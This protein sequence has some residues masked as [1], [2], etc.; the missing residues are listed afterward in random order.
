MTR[1]EG[2]NQSPDAKNFENKKCFQG[3]KQD[4]NEL[5]RCRDHVR[6]SKTAPKSISKKREKLFKFT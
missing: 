4:E 5:F 1:E 6:V 2:K 3:L